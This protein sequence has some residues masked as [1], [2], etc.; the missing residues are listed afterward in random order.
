MYF[1][2]FIPL[3]INVLKRDTMLNEMN[4]QVINRLEIT[5]EKKTLADLVCGMDGTMRYA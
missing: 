1:E 2:H 3:R 4:N 5:K